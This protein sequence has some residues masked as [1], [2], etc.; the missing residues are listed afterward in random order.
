MTLKRTE[1]V[2][3]LNKLAESEPPKERMK[4]LST[5]HECLCRTFARN[6]TA[7]VRAYVDVKPA[8]VEQLDYSQYICGLD[9][10]TYF[11]LLR[12]EP[13]KESWFLDIQPSILCPLINLRLNGGK[14]PV[15]TF[16][17]S[18]TEV[19]KQFAR[20]ITKTFLYTL[21]NAWE[22]IASLKLEFEIIQT[23]SDP[24]LIQVVQPNEIYVVLCFDIVFGDKCG[25]ATLC[26][27][28]KSF[29]MIAI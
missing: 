1:L 28:P 23:E 21:K 8:F 4:M 9:S 18:L 19:E 16:H 25:C 27:P 15:M 29:E 26:I 14:V 12:A 13:L 20:R 7:L 11:N 24:Q 17:R 22:N 10:P 5:I 2:E 3:R 6:L